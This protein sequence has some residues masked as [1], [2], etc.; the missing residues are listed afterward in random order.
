MLM[1]LNTMS[2]PKNRKLIR[3]AQE[4]GRKM[5]PRPESFFILGPRPFSTR[6]QL[7]ISFNLGHLSDGQGQ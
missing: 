4:V 1:E 3:D 5:D 6:D 2:R 7:S